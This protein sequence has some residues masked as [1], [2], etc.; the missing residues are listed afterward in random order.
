MEHRAGSLAPLPQPHALSSCPM[1]Y[2]NLEEGGLMAGE[3]KLQRKL[4]RFQD[5]D[6]WEKGV[7]I[8]NKLFDIALNGCFKG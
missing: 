5:L 7:E 1:P 3:E 2:A 8:G 4:F 6:V